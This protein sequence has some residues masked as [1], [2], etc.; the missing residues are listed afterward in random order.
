MQR[1]NSNLFSH[2][3]FFF[4]KAVTVLL[5]VATFPPDLSLHGSRVLGLRKNT[6]CFVIR[7]QT[8]GEILYYDASLPRSG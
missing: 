1:M 4:F 6:V 2:F 5:S 3:L 7:G 8:S